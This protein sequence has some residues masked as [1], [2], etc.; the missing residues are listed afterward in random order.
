MS[1]GNLPIE[2]QKNIVHNILK[3]PSTVLQNFFHYSLV[4]RL[5]A[6]IINFILSKLL[7]EC[8]NIN[9]F[10]DQHSE[11]ISMIRD[12][13]FTV[14][15]EYQ[16]IL[17][18]M[19]SNYLFFEEY[20]IIK[21]M[22]VKRLIEYFAQFYLS[23]MK[24]DDIYQ[25]DLMVVPCTI[26]LNVKLDIIR[27]LHMVLDASED[28]EVFDELHY[29]IIKYFDMCFTEHGKYFLEEQIKMMKRCIDGLPVHIEN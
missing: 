6:T 3:N 22:Y 26:L 4:C 27:S 23:H 17:N 11:Q 1:F 2:I 24:W 21:P 16:F 18:N 29:H 7:I 19:I 14:S 5:L 15:A 20:P 8:A 28:H 10:I 25:L 13:K 12:I 9:Y